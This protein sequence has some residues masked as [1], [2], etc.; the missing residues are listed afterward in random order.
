MYG[1]YCVEYDGLKH[2]DQLTCPPA[3]L[4]YIART[5]VHRAVWSTTIVSLC[6]AYWTSPPTIASTTAHIAVVHVPVAWL[7]PPT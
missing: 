2:K 4:L 3:R 6:A 7:I 1:V 5:P